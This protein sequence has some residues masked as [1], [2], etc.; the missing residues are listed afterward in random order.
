MKTEPTKPQQPKV[1][2][3]TQMSPDA[4]QA[5]FDSAA[6]V[7]R[8]ENVSARDMLAALGAQ[9]EKLRPSAGPE[10]PGI[11]EARR[12]ARGINA[13]LR[14]AKAGKIRIG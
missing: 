11:S 13:I 8:T 6:R 1:S 2:L 3:P 10:K 4:V 12:V 9:V 14:D 5:V 7:E